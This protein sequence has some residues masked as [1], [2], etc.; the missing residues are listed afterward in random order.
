MQ[1][2]VRMVNTLRK[3][4]RIEDFGVRTEAQ[5]SWSVIQFL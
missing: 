4:Y 3:S 5:I 2:V 1:C